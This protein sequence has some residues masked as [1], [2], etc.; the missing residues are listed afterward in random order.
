[1][2]N[3]GV[4]KAEELRPEGLKLFSEMVQSFWAGKLKSLPLT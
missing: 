1:M 4:R 3:A 2:Q